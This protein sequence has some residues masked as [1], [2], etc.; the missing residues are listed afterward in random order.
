MTGLGV[1]YALRIKASAAK[2]LDAIDSTP[3]RRRIVDAIQTLVVDPRPSTCKKLA[4]RDAAYRLRVG[5]YRIVYTVNDRE[6]IVEII[7]IG[8]RREVYRG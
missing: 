2:E 7:K 3:N 1:T 6:I 5:D 4:G 8:H